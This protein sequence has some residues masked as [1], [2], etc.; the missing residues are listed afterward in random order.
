MPSS[1][2]LSSSSRRKDAF[3][4]VLVC[5]SFASAACG[6]EPSVPS[7]VNG[8]EPSFGVQAALVEGIAPARVRTRFRRKLEMPKEPGLLGI[9]PPYDFAGTPAAAK[10]A[11]EEAR[12][13]DNEQGSGWSERPEPGKRR[14]IY[15]DL[16]NLEEHE[17][18]YDDAEMARLW[19]QGNARGINLASTGGE[20]A[21]PD[22]FP[23]L[24]P[25]GLSGGT[26]NR[27]VKPI[28]STYTIFH[29]ILMRM[30][31]LNNGCTA[32]LVGR[33][34]VLTAAHC[35]V[36]TDLSQTNQVYRARRSNTQAPFGAESTSAYWW[37]A[38]YSGS[39]CHITYTT[40]T[41][42]VC[43]KWDWAL[44]RLRSDAWTGSPNGTPSWMGYWVPGESAMTNNNYARNDGY[45]I[46]CG[47]IPWAPS[48]CSSNPN[49]VYGETAGRASARFRGLGGSDNI[50][51]IFNTANDIGPG[52]S[53]GAVW[54]NVYPNGTGGPYVL[55]I[56]TNEMC[57]TCSPPETG[58]TADDR[59]YPAMHRR[60]SPWLG[61][62]ITDKRVQYP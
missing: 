11:E 41:R 34:L 4:L 30:G 3:R 52:H 38:Q 51:L 1:A 2:Q 9:Y 60:M 54:S 14:V 33:R 16:E 55:A 19:E 57:G 43:G 35:V 44:L 45:P 27:V 18:E 53:G 36:N 21:S 17:L 40:A 10:A 50:N 47:E 31:Q 48:N 24:K 62:F 12:I 5:V 42:E 39:N 28:N 15:T 26:D 20:E 49:T 13:R 37:D 6:G 56:S 32:T 7:P 59:A 58:Y 22:P 29:N 8:G 46:F 25:Q 61:G 23:G